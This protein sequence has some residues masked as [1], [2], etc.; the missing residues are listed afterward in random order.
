MILSTVAI[1]ASC[2]SVLMTSILEVEVVEPGE[3][4]VFLLVFFNPAP[5][6][7]A[8]LLLEFINLDCEEGD[9]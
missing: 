8:S 7:V 3:A 5:E 9:R 6:P 4:L 2:L 1:P